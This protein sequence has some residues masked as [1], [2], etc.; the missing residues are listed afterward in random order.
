MMEFGGSTPAARI[1]DRI[2]EKMKDVLNG[3]D[4]QPLPS[5]PKIARWNNNA[6]WCRNT[7]VQEGLLKADSPRGI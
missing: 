2:G 1:L 6:Q 3:Y 4:R 7:L 5:Q